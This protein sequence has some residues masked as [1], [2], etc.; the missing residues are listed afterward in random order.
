MPKTSCPSYGS[1]YLSSLLHNF[2]YLISAEVFTGQFDA[3]CEYIDTNPLAT[4]QV[5]EKHII[6]V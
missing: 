6:G 4:P 3:I 1:A 5:V 2:D